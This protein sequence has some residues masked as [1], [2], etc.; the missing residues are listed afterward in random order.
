M[1]D[2][3][4]SRLYRGVIA[5]H[6]RVPHFFEKRPDAT[7]IIDAY[8]PMCGDKFKLYLDIENDVIVR[9]TFHGYGCAVS[10]A[11]TS[12]LMGKIQGL[13]LSQL[14]DIIK[15]F[16]EIVASGTET[17]DPEMAAFAAARNFP[18]REKCATLAWVGVRNWKLEIGN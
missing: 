15:P 3:A 12:V 8:N 5:E 17:G 10:K 16:L 18:G 7:R 1:T 13:P 11:S 9:A 4:L 14:P 6:N 2:E